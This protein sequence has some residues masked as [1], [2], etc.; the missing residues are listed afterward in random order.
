MLLWGIV[1]ARGVLCDQ[2]AAPYVLAAKSMLARSYEESAGSSRGD[3]GKY[4]VW[5]TED[6]IGE[7]LFNRRKQRFVQDIPRGSPL[8]PG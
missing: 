5:M 7:D 3:A 4:R 8:G 2:T 1:W 6:R